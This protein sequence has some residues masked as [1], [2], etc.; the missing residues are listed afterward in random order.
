MTS[1]TRTN[2]R[3]TALTTAE[4]AFELLTCEPAPLVFDVRLVP[5]L[6]DATLPLDQLRRLL[7]YERYDSGTTDILWRQLTTTGSGMRRAPKPTPASPPGIWPPCSATP[8]GSCA[9]LT[10]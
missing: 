4:N 8:T 6:S 9:S 5:G 2:T 10:T 3:H 7:M 1:T